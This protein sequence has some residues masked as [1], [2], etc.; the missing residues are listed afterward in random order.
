MNN[1][2][3]QLAYNWITVDFND[4]DTVSDYYCQTRDVFHARL[5]TLRKYSELKI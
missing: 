5:K 4:V 1:N 2:I 3:K